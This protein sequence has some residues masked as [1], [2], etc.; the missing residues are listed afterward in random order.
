MSQKL[1]L[2]K[3]IAIYFDVYHQPNEHL[4]IID[5]RYTDK[6]VSITFCFHNVN[7]SLDIIMALEQ[8]V[9]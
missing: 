2:V 1:Y 7:F 3:K 6:F 4:T 9:L 5:F 8:I